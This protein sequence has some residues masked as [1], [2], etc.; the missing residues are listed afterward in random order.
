MATQVVLQQINSKACL[1]ISSIILAVAV[2][3]ADPAS[4]TRA[5]VHIA[6]FGDSFRRV[7][8]DSAE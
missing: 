8:S 6:A 1:V 7:L 4:A 5:K 3:M 2:W